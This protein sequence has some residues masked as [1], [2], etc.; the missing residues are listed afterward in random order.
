MPVALLRRKAA[1]WAILVGS[2][3]AL[4][5]CED[6]VA[7]SS[8]T[9]GNPTEIRVGFTDEGGAP[10]AIAGRVE[11]YGATQIPVP[12]FRPEPL[13]RFD[14]DGKAEL[15]LMPGDFEG[16]ADSLWP[17]GS[18]EGDTLVR[19]NLVVIGADRGA[20]VRDLGYLPDSGQFILK[21]GSWKQ[22][23][24]RDAVISAGLV[25]LVGYQAKIDPQRLDPNR[26]NYLF[27][28]GTPY[29][30]KSNDGHFLFPALP[31]GS[32]RISF[33]TL[34][35]KDRNASPE[36][37]ADVYAVDRPLVPGR[38][39]TLSAFDL[40]FRLPMPDRYKP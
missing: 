37:T 19:F 5:H 4:M 18:W 36:D 31:D 9:T 20:I 30:S 29:A 38:V 27:L 32:H 24:G 8:V 1:A 11:V 23:E 40:E 15:R 6:R 7:G 14:V 26:F 12:G 3:F 39:D 28:I 17:V 13:A 25:D 21:D 35:D 22:G 34:P 16:I 33:M 10:A 2:A